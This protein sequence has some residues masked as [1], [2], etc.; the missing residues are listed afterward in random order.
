LSLPIEHFFNMIRISDDNV[1]FLKSHID[2]IGVNAKDYSDKTLLHEAAE[3]GR[4]QI[5]DFLISNGANVNAKDRREFTPLHW[6][7]WGGNVE[8]VKFL[9]SKGADVNAKCEDGTTPLLL[10]KIRK[11]REF[12]EIAEYLRSVSTTSGR[13]IATAVY[14]PKEKAILEEEAKKKPLRTIGVIFHLCLS[15][16]YL[17]ILW[18]TDIIRNLWYAASFIENLPLVG[19]PLAIGI[20]SIIFLRKSGYM[21]GWLTLVGMV[22][23]QS[24]TVCVWEGNVGFLFIKLIIR[25]VVTLLSAIPGIILTFWE[26]DENLRKAREAAKK[27]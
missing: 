23:V 26:L 24:I 13:Y 3:N 14:G 4:I 18:R 2:E 8:V 10:A 27:G 11:E 12:V 16:V 6:A 9:V 15:A 21:S 7:V 19:F 17:F 25:F 22:F 5:V 20:V 1:D